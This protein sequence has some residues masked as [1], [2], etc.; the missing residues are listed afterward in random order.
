MS[1]QQVFTDDSFSRA[2]ADLDIVSYLEEIK[3]EFAAIPM[4][5]FQSILTDCYLNEET[6]SLENF[7]NEFFPT[8]L[9]RMSEDFIS[10]ADLLEDENFEDYFDFLSGIGHTLFKDTG[11]YL[12]E[13]LEKVAELIKAFNTIRFTASST[14]FVAI[15][16]EDFEDYSRDCAFDFGF[17]DHKMEIYVDWEKYAN[18]CRIDYK[19]ETISAELT[20]NYSGDV[21]I[22]A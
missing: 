18:D 4:S 1:Q 10:V 12:E 21:L 11:K 9:S 16:D 17:L 19:T 20:L 8:L 2:F 13:D 14:N 5:A 22:R 6:V 7:Y 15:A 3:A